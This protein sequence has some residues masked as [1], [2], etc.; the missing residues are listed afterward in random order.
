MGFMHG[1]NNCICQGRVVAQEKYEGLLVAHP[2][3]SLRTSSLIKHIMRSM[4]ATFIMASWEAEDAKAKERRKEA[5]CLLGPMLQDVSEELHGEKPKCVLSS[6][7]GPARNQVQGPQVGPGHL[8][9]FH[10]PGSSFWYQNLASCFPN[11]TC[12]SL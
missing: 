5:I 2:L 9:A 3:S 11:S 7:S 8:G 4:V 1:R 10:G 12:P 6:K